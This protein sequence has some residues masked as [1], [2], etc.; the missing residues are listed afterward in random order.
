MHCDVISMIFAYYSKPNFSRKKQNDELLLKKLPTH[1]NFT[2]YTEAIKLWGEI[3][4]HKHAP[5]S[6]RLLTNLDPAIVIISNRY[7]LIT[8]DRSSDHVFTITAYFHGAA[9]AEV[10]V[11][12]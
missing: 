5:A 3:S 2:L 9:Q 11:D 12:T 1:F 6:R 4:L 7:V 8:F 10:I